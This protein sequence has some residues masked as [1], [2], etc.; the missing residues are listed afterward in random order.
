MRILR[1]GMNPGNRGHLHL[2]GPG[3]FEVS[4][5]HERSAEAA[6]SLLRAVRGQGVPGGPETALR[7][8]K[9]PK[10]GR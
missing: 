2:F 9:V 4:S 5:S 6:G 8:S 1:G 7:S 10:N 3:N